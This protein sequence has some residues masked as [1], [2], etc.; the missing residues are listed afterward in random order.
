MECYYVDN[1]AYPVWTL[2]SAATMM[3]TNEAGEILYPS[4]QTRYESGSREYEAFS[5]TTP[6]S[7]ITSYPIDPFASQV[8]TFGYVSWRSPR[9][10]VWMLVSPGPDGVFDIP[11]REVV[12]GQVVGT[13]LEELLRPYTYDPSNGTIS[14]GDIYRLRN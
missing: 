8:Q 5:I 3:G 14:P 9:G 1:N 13:P 7:Y 12:D 6:I 2:E 11:W 10:V 4:F